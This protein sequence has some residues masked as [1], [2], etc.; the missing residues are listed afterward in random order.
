[1]T[2]D[3]L[4]LHAAVTSIMRAL[5]I[6]EK[7]I[8]VAHRE[9][10]FVTAD[11]E[12]MRF[13]AN[14]PGCKLSDLADYLDAVPTTASSIVDRLVER[15]FVLRERPETN[16]RSVALSLTSAG[17][18]AFTLIDAE[19]K[20]TMRLMLDALPEDDRAAFVRSMTRIAKSVS[21]PEGA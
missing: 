13:V 1:M 11:I 9:L 21:S 20:A 8:Q 14:N 2:D 7:H 5:K 10:N 19:E 12:T 4:S 18:E 17:S 3:V 16:R 15:G 6:A